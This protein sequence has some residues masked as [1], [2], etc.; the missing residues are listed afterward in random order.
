MPKSGIQFV[1]RRQGSSAMEQ[2]RKRS[3]LASSEKLD[4]DD[5][6]DARVAQR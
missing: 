1:A 5:E 6:F 3:G 2:P 4:D